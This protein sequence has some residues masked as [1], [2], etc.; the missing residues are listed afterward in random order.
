MYIKSLELANF[1]NYTNASITLNRGLNIF[2]GENAQGKT[3]VAEAIYYVGNLKSHRAVRDRELIKWGAQRAYIKADVV[4]ETGENTLEFL[5]NSED[6]KSVKINGVN[7]GKMS[8]V[9]GNAYVVIFSPEDLKLVKEGPSIR[10]RFIDTELNQIRPRYHYA[11]AQYNRV[12]IQRN[13]L[14]KSIIKS[15]SLKTMAEVYGEQLAEYG[16]FISSVRFE[17]VKK[18]SMISKIIHRKITDGREEL[19][20][21]YKCSTGNTLQREEI[22]KRL[23]EYYIN[24]IDDDVSRGYTQKGPHRDDL[25]IKINGI[26]VRTFGSQGQQRTAALSLKLSEI[27]IIKSEVSEYPVLLLDDVMSE[28][29]LKRQKYLLETLKIVQTV[30]TCTSL[31]D[32]NEYHFDE[33]EVFIVKEG[34]VK[35]MDNNV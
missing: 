35:R 20:V 15:P 16:G 30:L 24:N 22:K 19:E 32:I 23:L 3:N 7:A 18:L 10:R 5:I 12:L 26:D 9:L 31:N 25:E 29:D 8:E 11:L 17:F 6:K 2:V 34:V 13:N 21:N 33:K 14:L 27:D 4:K 1:R 28:L